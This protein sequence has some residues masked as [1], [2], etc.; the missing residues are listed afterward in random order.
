MGNASSDQ[1]TIDVLL[2]MSSSLKIL[3]KGKHDRSRV[4]IKGSDISVKTADYVS[5]SF[6][7]NSGGEIRIY[8]DIET[9]PHNETGEELG[10]GVIQID[11]QGNTDGLRAQGVNSLGSART[12]IYS[13]NKD[14]DN[15]FLIF[16]LLFKVIF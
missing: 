5:L 8:Q 12:L 4:R 9:L 15:F 6:S 2:D 16:V 1:V 7:G 11:A 13:S 14:E 3:V 10:A